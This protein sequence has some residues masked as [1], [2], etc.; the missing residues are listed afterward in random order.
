MYLK[1]KR[2]HQ[3]ICIRRMQCHLYRPLEYLGNF[4][5]YCF[6]GVCVLR[7]DITANG[8]HRYVHIHRQNHMD[9]FSFSFNA[10][11]SDW[12]S[13]SQG[14]V[15]LSPFSHLTCEIFS[16]YSWR[17]LRNNSFFVTWSL[18]D[19]KIFQQDCP[20]IDGIQLVGGSGPFI[21]V[22]RGLSSSMN[23]GPAN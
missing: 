3:Y 16:W 15:P 2:L 9:A 7:Q 4:I 14:M 5:S 10:N 13:K 21:K 17:S 19:V 8:T 1:W 12:K 6:A 23:A 20:F 18:T 11:I 22:A